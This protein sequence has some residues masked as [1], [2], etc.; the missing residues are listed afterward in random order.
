MGKKEVNI[1][2]L[3]LTKLP[4]SIL[5]EFKNSISSVLD[6][7]KYI[8]GRFVSQF[9]DEW[10][11]FTGAQYSIGVANGLD[12]I[13]ISLTAL[14]VKSGD[15][16]AVP[17]HTFIA[18]WFAVRNIGAIP[19]GIDVDENG[20]MDLEFLEASPE[21]FRAVIPVHLHGFTIDMK[22][23]SNWAKSKDILIVEDCSQAHGAI[24]SGHHVGT[25]GD[26]GAFSLYPTK[27]L[28]ALGDAGIITVN[29]LDLA[30][31]IRTIANYG[32][33]PVDKYLHRSLGVNSRL[34]PIQAAVL[35]VNLKYL[36]EWN[37]R[38]REIATKY[39]QAINPHNGSVFPKSF[40]VSEAVWHHF[41]FLSDDR[42]QIRESLKSWG[43]N[44]EIHYP[45][46]ASTEYSRLKIDGNLR[47]AQDFPRATSISSR[48]LSLPIHPFM[49][50]KQVEYVAEKINL[51]ES[52]DKKE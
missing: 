34:D 26:A 28:G 4:K 46:C 40:F 9:E 1:P 25:M 39:I 21:N 24:N 41:I 33:D 3:D 42:D 12:A 27:N 45:V 32:A 30:D 48:T 7:G 23:L 43:V 13:S 36:P 37:E 8:G 47:Y 52:P 38:R 17:A 6:E 16:V 22:R 14:G 2:F 50:T 44:T 51:L 31:R 15:L 18:T 20:L 11:N 35:S 10:S 49:S 5:N 29:N 19:I